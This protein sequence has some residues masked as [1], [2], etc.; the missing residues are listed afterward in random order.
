VG[1][2]AALAPVD[3]PGA[4]AEPAI[5][6]STEG[7]TLV[8]PA[9]NEA[10]AIDAVLD[11]L[12]TELDRWPTPIPHE[13]IV[14]DDGSTDGTGERLLSQ[15]RP[16]VRVVRHDVNLGYGAAIKTGAR[17]ACFPWLV[18]TDADGTYPHEAISQLLRERAAYDMI[19]GARVGKQRAVPLVRRPAKWLLG[20]LASYLSRQ[21]IP[22]LNSGLRVIDRQLFERYEHILPHGFSLTTT[23]T[24]AMLSDGRRVKYLPVE[25]LKRTGRSKIRPIADTLNFLILI[26]RT[27]VYFEPLRVFLPVSIVFAIVSIAVAVGSKI[28]TGRVMD[29]TTVVLFV[30]AVQLAALGMIADVLSRRPR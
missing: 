18:I 4:L 12:R 3:P 24:L 16:G 2:S 20:A 25:Y 23:I 11:G 6:R 13:V 9:Y 28:L 10:G 15:P 1:R 8:I 27:V 26:V 30:T 29:V 19:V 5:D 17:E 7:F 14:V 22:D 21:R